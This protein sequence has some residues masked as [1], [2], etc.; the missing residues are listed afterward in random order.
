[1]LDLLHVAVDAKGLAKNAGSQVN[2]VGIVLTIVV[3]GLTALMAWLAH[4]HA[5]AI[6][7]LVM[8]VFVGMFFVDPTGVENF[9]KSTSSAL[10]K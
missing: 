1:M 6:G 5:A 7:A 9:V 2:A 4:K 8:S 3:G 10:L